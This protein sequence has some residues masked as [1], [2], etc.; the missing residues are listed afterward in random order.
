M[1]ALSHFLTQFY[2]ILYLNIYIEFY[3]IL[4][5]NIHIENFSIDIEYS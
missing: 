5:L 4:Y 3:V 2:V 1:K